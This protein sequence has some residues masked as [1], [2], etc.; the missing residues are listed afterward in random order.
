MALK[1]KTATLKS[2]VMVCVVFV[3]LNLMKV[4][5]QSANESELE[6]SQAA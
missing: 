2:L 1:L 4:S 5:K 3:K 6:T